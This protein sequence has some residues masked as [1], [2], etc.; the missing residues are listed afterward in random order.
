MTETTKTQVL[1]NIFYK[2]VAAAIVMCVTGGIFMVYAIKLS[3]ELPD[4]DSVK[5]M[6]AMKSVPVE[7]KEIPEFLVKSV[8]AAY[9]PGFFTHRGLDFARLK[10]YALNKYYGDRRYDDSPTIT[11]MVSKMALMAKESYCGGGFGEK[12]ARKLKELML[13]LK[14]EMKIKSKNKIFEIYLNNAYF[15]N[16]IYGLL[17]AS[18]VYFN[19]RPSQLLPAECAVL[20]AMM[21]TPERRNPYRNPAEAKA[22]QR[23]VLES[24]AAGGLISGK[25]LEE[26]KSEKIKLQPFIG[27]SAGDVARSFI[28]L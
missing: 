11:Q 3:M 7:F 13:A 25:E 19:K 12:N 10:N 14:L 9:D 15:G 23:E 26:L 18:S 4:T 5:N 2:M 16:N 1:V 8:V 17:E 21:S 27:S 20:A 24:M 6:V 28:E 22:G